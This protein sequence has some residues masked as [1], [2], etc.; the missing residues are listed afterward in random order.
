M[1]NNHHVG[2]PYR[3]TKDGQPWAQASVNKS[4]KEWVAY[5]TREK[6]TYRYIPSK[7]TSNNV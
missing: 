7:G 2:R 1:D 3:M 4:T 5:K 6:K